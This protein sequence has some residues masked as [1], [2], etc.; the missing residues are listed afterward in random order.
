MSRKSKSNLEML[1]EQLTTK[2]QM[3]MTQNQR[4]KLK[5]KADRA[6]MTDSELIRHWID[7]KQVAERMAISDKETVTELRK[8]GG[9]IRQHFGLLENLGTENPDEYT[10]E[11]KKSANALYKELI[12]LLKKLK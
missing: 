7:N 1:D 4:E 11:M 5:A 6:D 2:F 9:S 12:E 3:R 10:I 8:L